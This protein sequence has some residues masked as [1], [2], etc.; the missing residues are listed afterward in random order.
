VPVAATN[1][2]FPLVALWA[3]PVMGSWRASMGIF[4]EFPRILSP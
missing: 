3:N 2:H 4:S 1:G